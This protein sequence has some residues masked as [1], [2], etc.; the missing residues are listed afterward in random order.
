MKST[1]QFELA[2]THILHSIILQ[3]NIPHTN[4]QHTQIQP[5]QWEHE[6]TNKILF[7][8]YP[9]LLQINPKKQQAA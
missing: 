6:T 8:F 2:A 4:I 3:N 7:L 5:L 9:V 1:D